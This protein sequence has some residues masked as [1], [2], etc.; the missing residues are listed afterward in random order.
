MDCRIHEGQSTLG[1]LQKSSLLLC[2][3]ETFQN[4]D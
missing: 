3:P 2:L 1:A 4:G